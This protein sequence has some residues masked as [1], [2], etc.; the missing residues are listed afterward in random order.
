MGLRETF[1]THVSG[2]DGLHLSVL[3]IEPDNEAKIKGIVQLVHGMAE[4]K[5]RYIDFMKFLANKGYVVVIHDNRGHGASVKSKDDLGFM[6]SGGYKALIED[7][8]EITLETKE[9]VKEATG[10]DDLPFALLGHSMGSAAVRCYI[11]EYDDE[12]DKLGVLGCPSERKETA[13]GLRFVQ[14][15]QMFVG[16]RKRSKL[17]AMIVMGSYNQKFKDEGMSNS[18]LCSDPEVVREYNADPLCGYKY[19]ISGYIDVIKLTLLTYTDKGYGMKN[20]GLKIKFF[21]GSDDPCGISKDAIRKA[22]RLIRKQG[23][24]NISGKIYSG[25]RHEILNERGKEKVYADILK[26]IQS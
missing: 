13:I 21:S 15:L 9:Y 14:L 12:I 26:F 18:W 25:M 3:R 5:E 1:Y 19:T 2:S 24:R 4:H 16:A 7:V 22:I 8:H 11:R 6:Y 10:R 20:P 23:Y 17:V